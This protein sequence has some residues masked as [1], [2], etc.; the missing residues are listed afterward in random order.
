VQEGLK[1]IVVVIDNAGYSSVGRVS[2]QVGS[3]GFGCHFR[4]RG[5]SGWY[6]GETLQVDFVGMCRAMGAAAVRAET[7]EELEAALQQARAADVTTCIYVPT[8]WDERVPGYASCW[9]DMATAQVSTIPAVAEARA[10]YERDKS[11]ERYLMIP[12]HPHWAPPS[13]AGE[14][15]GAAQEPVSHV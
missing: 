5:E 6:D 7:R 1:V 10:D 2:E 9:W 3:E 11:R 15:E 4:A 8:D 14:P 13:A 12:G